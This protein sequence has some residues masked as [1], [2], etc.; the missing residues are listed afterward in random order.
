MCRPFRPIQSQ[1]RTQS[2]LEPG[3]SRSA[4][5]SR[6]PPPRTPQPPPARRSPVSRVSTLARLRHVSWPFSPSASRLLPSPFSTELLNLWPKQLL[7]APR[8]LCEFHHVGAK[9][10]PP[11]RERSR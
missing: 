7:P 10:C 4:Y 9:Q 1:A 11:F 8:E 3:A 5:R 2:S 6:T